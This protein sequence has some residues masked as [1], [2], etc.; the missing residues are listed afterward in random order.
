MDDKIL[1]EWISLMQEGVHGQATR[2]RL[3]GMRLAQL[4]RKVSPELS[5]ALISGLTESSSLTR[6]APFS[7]KNAPDLLIIEHIDKLENTPH[8]PNHVST[9]LHRIINEWAL[10]DKLLEADLYPVRTI[11]LYG[12]PGVGKTLA[13]R[14]LA[15]QLEMPL[16]TLDIA[17]TINSYLGKTGQN[18]AKA[19]EYA[20]TN[21]CILFFDEFD[22]LGKRR[23]DN[24]DVGELKRVVNVLLQAIDQ[25]HGPSILVA[26][27]N[28]E[29]L[30]DKAILRRFE[31]SIRF[32]PA[33][34]QQINKVLKSLGVPSEF[35]EKLSKQFQGQP[36]SNATRLVTLA[37]KRQVLN[38]ISFSSSLELITKELLIK[39]KS[40]QRQEVILALHKA[41]KSAHQIARELSISHTT[42]LRDLKI[43]KE[44]SNE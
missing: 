25:W 13:V 8:W 2:F 33:T 43:S 14:W 40:Q 16:A 24:Y 39:S 44:E 29:L 12:P 1:R 35:S 42:V 28:H 18:I 9:E 32:P 5:Y 19:L 34:S 37:R 17:T 15:Q 26:A 10:K 3:R 31:T 11:L 22:A 21:P 30:L 38:K 41:G 36:I 23:D 20:R 7:E 27:T 4:I 6:L